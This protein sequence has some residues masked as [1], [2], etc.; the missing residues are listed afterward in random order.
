MP[1]AEP[2]PPKRK[3]KTRVWTIPHTCN[4]C[5]ADFLGQRHQKACSKQCRKVVLQRNSAAWELKGGDALRRR[6]CENTKRRLR[7]I[8]LERVKAN[9]RRRLR[10]ILHTGSTGL[11]TMIGCSS[12]DLRAWLESKFTGKMSWENY[13][14]YWVVD[15]RIPLASFDL[16]QKSHRERACHYT[17]LQPLTARKNLEK[18]DTITDAQ[19][20]ML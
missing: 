6:C 2:K 8:P 16:F 4:I 17:N 18:S 15:H 5:G 1:R 19:L 20:S 14:I 10:E 9:L 11:S 12:A 13:G 3:I 7:E